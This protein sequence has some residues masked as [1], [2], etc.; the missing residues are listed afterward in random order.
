MSYRAAPNANVRY[1]FVSNLKDETFLLRQELDSTKAEL[2]AA[3]V[4]LEALRAGAG[5]SVVPA[6]GTDTLSLNGNSPPLRPATPAI[7][8]VDADAGDAVVA[9]MIGSLEKQ[10]TVDTTDLIPL[11]VEVGGLV[12]SLYT[13]TPDCPPVQMAEI[14]LPTPSAPRAIPASLVSCT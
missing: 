5:L 4:E 11:L 9:E 12:K 6:A 7:T 3:K 14:V 8:I 10:P 2:L 13:V 1:R